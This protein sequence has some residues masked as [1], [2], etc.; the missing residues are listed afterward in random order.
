MF[1]VNFKYLH[2]FVFELHQ[3]YKYSDLSKERTRLI[4]LLTPP[5]KLKIEAIFLTINRVHIYKKTHNSKINENGNKIKCFM[6]LFW[7]K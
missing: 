7:R 4:F 3:K 2:L 5:S 1:G 6:Y